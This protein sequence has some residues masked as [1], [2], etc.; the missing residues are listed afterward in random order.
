MVACWM[1]VQ[2]EQL[3]LEV[4]SI[5]V[6]I[7]FSEQIEHFA[8]G[9]GRVETFELKYHPHSLTSWALQQRCHSLSRSLDHSYVWMTH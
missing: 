5:V 1:V 6:E 9:T 7:L 8:T 3:V 4:A 2:V